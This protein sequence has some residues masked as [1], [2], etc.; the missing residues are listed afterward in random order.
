MNQS[1][2]MNII[3]KNKIIRNLRKKFFSGK[4]WGF[5]PICA[6]VEF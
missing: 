4:L 5:F 3:E 1:N 6:N 2:H